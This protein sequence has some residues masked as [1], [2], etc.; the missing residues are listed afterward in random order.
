MQ[1]KSKPYQRQ[2][3]KQTGHDAKLKSMRKTSMLNFGQLKKDR[4]LAV[5]K[6]L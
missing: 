3:Q 1:A 2:I 4:G 6:N 5:I